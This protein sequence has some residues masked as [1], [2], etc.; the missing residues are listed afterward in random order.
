MA[1]SRDEEERK[2]RAAAR[3]E[4]AAG[5]SEKRAELLAQNKKNSAASATTKTAAPSA[6]P[7]KQAVTRSNPA[8]YASSTRLHPTE[9]SGSSAKASQI[10]SAAKAGGLTTS[11]GYQKKNFGDNDMIVAQYGK[12]QQTFDLASM[13]YEQ[14]MGVAVRIVDDKER[15]SFLKAAR[16]QFS[17][18][19]NENYMENVPTLEEMRA[20][21]NAQ[22][23]GGVYQDYGKKY[24][25][26]I[27]EQFARDYKNTQNMKT[28]SSLYDVNGNAINANT[29]DFATVVQGI[30][31]IADETKRK[32]AIASLKELIKTE[33]SR[34]YGQTIDEKLLGTY[35]GSPEFTQDD[36]ENVTGRFENAFYPQDGYDEQN[37]ETYF[38]FVDR[39]K[40]GGY[41][42]QAQRQ[43]LE[44]LDE[45][46]KNSTGKDI[47]VRTEADE[48][49]AEPAEEEKGEPLADKIANALSGVGS[50]WNE[51]TDGDRQFKPEEELPGDAQEV[52][53]TASAAVSDS[54]SAPAQ[55]GYR[56]NLT[57]PA[58]QELIEAGVGVKGT[59][60]EEQGPVQQIVQED[61]EDWEAL[62]AYMRGEQLSN[63][64]YAKIARFIEDPDVS[65][66]LL[67]ATK[68]RGVE[69]AL[70]GWSLDDEEGNKARIA[71]AK[72]DLAQFNRLGKTLGAAA[73][74]LSTGALPADMTNIGYLMLG[75]VMQNV[76]A[77]VENGY[78]T[79]PEGA[80]MYEHV[81]ASDPEL[82]QKVAQV[83]GL[84]K[85]VNDIKT[86]NVRKANE[87]SEQALEDAISASI[88]GTA[89]DDQVSMVANQPELADIDLNRD[90]LRAQ[91]RFQLNKAM[92][93]EDDGAFWAG[94]SAAAQEGRTI[95]ELSGN[96][97]VYP[98]YK[99]ELKE[100]ALGVIDEY[101]RVAMSHGM[102]LETYLSQTGMDLDGMMDIAYNRMLRDGAQVLSNP[103]APAEIAAAAQVQS[104][105][106]VTAAAMGAA[107]GVVSY[108]E[109]FMNAPYQVIDIATYE[110]RRE[111]IMDDYVRKYGAQAPAM[112]RQDLEEYAKSGALDDESTAAL[113]ANI[114][115]AANIFDV[116][117]DI[118]PTFLAGLYRDSM[119]G[120]G[121][122]LDELEADAALMPESERWLFNAVSGLTNNLTAMG[123][124]TLTGGAAGKLGAGARLASV[125]GTTAGYGLTEFDASYEDYRS[126][127]MSE[128]MAARM[129][130]GKAA[131]TVA[132]NVGGTGSSIDMYFG[133][134]SA[135]LGFMAAM[136]EK[137]AVG[138]VTEMGKQIGEK[139]VEEGA[140]EVNEALFGYAYDLLDGI[141][142]DIDQGKKVTLSTG[143]ASVAN[144]FNS[145]DVKELG[146]EIL[147]SGLAGAVYGG[148]FS[149]GGIAVNA[150]KSAKQ[151]GL[152]RRYNSI[153]LSGQ[154]VRGEL[155]PTDANLARVVRALKV[156]VNDPKFRR[157]VD[158]ADA[159]AL[160]VQN[161]ATAAMSGVGNDLRNAALE[162]S[163]QA[164]EY[165]KKAELATESIA[166]NQDEYLKARKEALMGSLEATKRLDGFRIAWAEAGTALE[167]ATN[168]AKKERA[169]AGLKTAE[170][171]AECRK[172]AGQMSAQQM[173]DAANQV[174]EA[175]NAV[176]EQV[177]AQEDAEIMAQAQIDAQP[178]EAESPPLGQ[179]EN[180]EQAGGA[181]DPAEQAELDAERD[182]IMNEPLISTEYTDA[183]APPMDWDTNPETGEAPVTVSESVQAL[184]TKARATVQANIGKASSADSAIQVQPHHS[185]AQVQQINDYHN[186]VDTRMLSAAQKYKNDPAAGNIRTPVSEVSEREAAD[187]KNLTGV[188]VEG[189]THT[190]DKNFFVHVENRHGQNGEADQSMKSLEDVARVGWVIDNYDSVELLTNDNGDV[191]RAAGYLD[192]N[193]E[194]EPLIRYTKQL[195]GSV[196]VVE[197][198]GESKWK[199]LW[200]VSA[201]VQKNS[202][203]Q[204]AGLNGYSKRLMPSQ[205]LGT[206]SGTKMPSPVNQT[207]AQNNGA[208]KGDDVQADYVSMDNLR[209]QP[210]A[211]T[212]R[213][214]RNPIQTF[215]RLAKTLGIGQAFGTR[216]MNGL[217]G[218]AA[219]YYAVQPQYVASDT[220]HASSIETDAHELGHAIAARLNMTGTQQMINNLTAR[221]PANYAA[222]ELPGEAF[223]EFFWRYIVND[224]EADSFAGRNYVAAFERNLRREGLLRD[225]KRAQREIRQYL[226]ATV[227]ERYRLM[228]RD[229]SDKRNGDTLREA[230]EAK[231]REYVTHYVDSTRPA[232]DVNAAVR[233]A[234]GGG[235][236]EEMNLRHAALMQS[237]A[238][239]R[240]S[241][242][243]ND[244]L[245]DVNGT[246]VGDSLRERFRRAGIR[247]EDMDRLTAYMIAKHSLDRDAQDKVVVDRGAIH[248][249]ETRAYIQDVERNSPEIAR[250]AQAFQSFRHD[251]MME[252][253]VNTGY[254]TQQTLALFEAMYPNYVPTYRVKDRGRRG[255]GGQTYTI[256]RATGSTEEIINPIDSFVDMV[257]TIV[258]MNLR[259]ETLKTWDRVHET[260]EGM[261]IFGRRVT[262]DTTTARMDMRGVQQQVENILN[263]AGAA[264]DVIQQIMDAIGETQYRRRGTGDVNLPSVVSV[265]M[266]DGSMR[267]YEMFDQE[268]FDMMAGTPDNGKSGLGIIGNITRFMTAMT[269]GS[270]PIFGIRNALRDYQ[271]SVNYGSWASNYVTG[272]GRWLNAAWDVFRD[273]W[274]GEH[275]GLN[276]RND[277]YE[278]YKALGGGGWTRIETG[279]R[280]GAEAYR[281]ELFE[282]YNTSNIGRTAK[283]AGKKVWNAVTLS[284]LNEIIEQTS[285]YAEFK[286]GQHDLTTPQGRREAYL[287]AQ[288]VT[289][290]FSRKGSSRM[291]AEL[292]A[293]IPFFNA[294]LQGIYRTGRQV[295]E[296]ERD[297]AGTRFMKTVVNTGLTSALAA[298]WS[299]KYLDDEDKEEFFYLSDDLK[300]KHMYLPNFAPDI[301]GESPLI[302]IPLNQDPLAY[303]I[304]AAVTNAAWSGE[305][306]EWAIELC[307][308]A[309]NIIQS[310]NP[311]GSTIFDPLIATQTNKNWYGSN[312]VP[313][314]MDGM[315]AT[316]QYSAETAQMFI[317]AS[318]VTD[319]LT[320]KAISPMMLQYIAE[321]YSGFV[322]QMVIP[323]FS[324]NEFTGEINGIDAVIEDVRNTLVSDPLR[325]NDVVSTV[326]DNVELLT[327]VTKAGSKGKPLDMLRSGLTQAEA[328]RAY[329]DAYE[330]THKG[331]VLYDAK[332]AIT[333]LYAKIDEIE[334]RTELSDEEKYTLQSEVRREMIEI[335]LDA[336]EEMAEF[337]EK[338]IDG[339][340]FLTRFMR[341][342]VIE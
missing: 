257:N 325:S 19:R 75:E 191:E 209:I 155:Q 147:T 90:G 300:A 334:A 66:D 274:I 126:K 185:P 56:P 158:N 264:D 234:T 14:A 322:G 319:A 251:F 49:E 100:T 116:A 55:S 26:G 12:Q 180:P 109:G 6:S 62:A 44:K 299:L 247:G 85:T 113:K 35:L 118:D 124:S 252:Y 84:L 208:V 10:V 335:A 212:G 91:Y 172:A 139:A 30:R 229:K 273:G 94:N 193:G 246:I 111:D 226:N 298:L 96:S 197:A 32:S 81:I 291:A 323:F 337:R 240:A 239:K 41:P 215:K 241:V 205:A 266:P 146:K 328:R 331:G 201:Y 338:Y 175:R 11:T 228:L 219:G 261:G 194:H 211:T 131:G 45:V 260:Y 92:W 184:R 220:R 222:A 202:P 284:R 316:N 283:W 20:Q 80:N 176:A 179:P 69:S 318:H 256:M 187:I 83:N 38:G 279:T 302:R 243:L 214:R 122:V 37:A 16:K 294:S 301:L 42:E 157:L 165:D 22:K 329:D 189:Y 341:G 178:S 225:V 60:G 87:A 95:R 297:R 288:D 103:D 327:T 148:I 73:N 170:W 88:K 101:T 138:L 36:Y 117:Y 127:G 244:Y 245:T 263:Q 296:S 265:Q 167:E 53:K 289:T 164:A 142:I 28:L 3:K 106:N 270:N 254:M 339:E 311:V 152:E 278:Q 330:M 115:R 236:A 218:Q 315:Y 216:K 40:N 97:G 253:M 2:R 8:E 221:F 71:A 108:A 107:H 137:G 310:L 210:T 286:H 130:F 34:F 250:A 23:P 168:A 196:Y 51:L 224:A 4:S 145:T 65:G 317:D 128:A 47:P 280:K 313:R 171:M 141:A 174:L 342:T 149:L 269:T 104:V 48:A 207:V 105:G 203:A 276:R 282:G 46:Y 121:K 230:L 272:L 314:S 223:A 259:N 287:A 312:I 267:F 166:K 67:L 123:V 231:E 275:T 160:E 31:S 285:R 162:A 213:A 169:T 125:I 50:W 133:G 204:N 25:K 86:E 154:I 324:K 307:A 295:T 82:Q 237:T 7:S 134:N 5:Y 99:R 33:G 258:A 290:D 277:T 320:G 89:T 102:D 238:T 1:Y 293:I 57:P 140:E 119:E 129:A 232:E 206:T 17:N 52:G 64:N 200:L 153:N 268:L 186:A 135:K 27:Q 72:S 262:E 76:K 54:A 63:E 281:G 304:H 156:D 93:Y 78:I 182:A 159:A 248:A 190:A 192:K 235:V 9:K 58:P 321:Q 59:R 195:N 188:D 227:E 306:E 120:L 309:D 173:Q 143:I 151:V 326:Y 336:N 15:D 29:A 150:V 333:D 110:S 217:E 183:D 198:V 21:L 161:V 70:E 68:S 77:R 199:K 255:L 271:N 24:S 61:L 43:M 144:A 305:G 136:R 303:A 114:A 242:V 181:V 249:D 39:I 340:S 163:R 233:E 74:M 332:A 292:K 98:E 79:I 112:Y 132:L 18:E 308:A 177:V 13:T